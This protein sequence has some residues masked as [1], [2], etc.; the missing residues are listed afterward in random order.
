[1]PIP[2]QLSPC[3]SICLSTSISSTTSLPTCCWPSIYSPYPSF[4]NLRESHT[5]TLPKLT[6]QAPS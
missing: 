5:C 2:M 6:Q 3:N 1:M 4:L